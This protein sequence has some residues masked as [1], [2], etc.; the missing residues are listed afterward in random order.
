MAA[1]T[2]KPEQDGMGY[3]Y[4]QYHADD[5]TIVRVDVLPPRSHPRPFFVSDEAARLMH[6][7]DWIV[8][9][10]GEEFARAQSRD[11]IE[12]AVEQKLVAR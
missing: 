12:K 11:A 9:A 1:L 5:G 2:L 4:G 3:F 6:E 8:Y 7:H 10:D